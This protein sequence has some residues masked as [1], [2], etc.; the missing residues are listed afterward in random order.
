MSERLHLFI[1]FEGGRCLGFEIVQP[2]ADALVLGAE[3]FQEVVNSQKL[4][5]QC[6]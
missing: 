6:I 4:V 1:I 5:S 3:N 2:F